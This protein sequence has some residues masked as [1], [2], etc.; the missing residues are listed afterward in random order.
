MSLKRKIKDISNIILGRD[1]YI[2]PKY[3][4]DF[5]SEDNKMKRVLYSFSIHIK[6]PYKVSSM[7]D[8]PIEN[9][10]LLYSNLLKSKGNVEFQLG[11][12]V[13]YKTILIPKWATNLIL[14]EIHGYLL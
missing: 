4:L 13:C 11:D 3:I 1:A 5:T 2:K 8:I 7:L 9:S 14:R 10:Q 12:N 6:Y